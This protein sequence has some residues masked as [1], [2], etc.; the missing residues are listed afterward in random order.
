MVAT[1]GDIDLS[2]G[3]GAQ[4]I[5][6]EPVRNQTQTFTIT[7]GTG[8]YVGATGSGTVQRTLSGETATGRIGRET[9]T[10]T[11]DVPGLEFDVTPP[12]LT[13][14]SAKR[15]RAPKRAT[16]VRV[17][18]NVTAQDS[19]D[20]AVAVSCVPRSG[21]RFRIGRTLVT[22][23]ASDSSGNARTARFTVTVTRRR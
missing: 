17:T 15:V 21:S 4:C 19:A 10:G 16:R 18:Y 11:L 9:W 8:I 20:G 6:Q 5:E 3:E 23:S 7:G 14:V 22:C 2:L 1:K 13:G 12:T